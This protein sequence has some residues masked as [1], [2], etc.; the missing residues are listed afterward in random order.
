MESADA[1][2]VGGGIAGLSA[3]LALLRAGVRRVRLLERES[4]P[5][6]HSSGRNAAIFRHLSTTAG[7]LDLA[8]RSRE[9]L[10]ELLGVEEAWLRRTGLWFVSDKDDAIEPLAALAARRR[11]PHTRETGSAVTGALPSLDGGPL[12][13][14]LWCPDD[15]VIDI[16]A[17]TQALVRAI[18]AA[19][20]V[21]SFGVEVAS[22]DL[23]G[24]RVTGLHLASG[25][26]LAAG[27][28]VLAA[29]AWGASLGAS[30]GA[31]LPLEP[32]RRHLAQLTSGA[33]HDPGGP[34]VWCL[35]DELYYRPESGGVLVSP[36]DS[37]PC[38]AGVPP[39][40]EAGLELLAK[41]LARLAP[42]LADASV[43]R[44]WACL[45]TF[46]PDN[47]A[48]V[49]PDPRRQG[50]FWLAGLGGHGMTGGVAAGEL[51]AATFTGRA[52]PL[53]DALSVSRFAPRES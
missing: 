26:H 48:V 30:C 35:G 41:K 40:T 53:A 17:V 37:D 4:E 51:L 2:I 28:V 33:R 16:H 25:D 20:G 19:G 39:P 10:G 34:V 49:G 8:R 7:D 15:G 46:T 6:A 9:L 29:G 23:D 21:L 1:I 11:Q 3:A 42:R 5:C 31:P 22:V 38:L 18:G 45:R 24:D 50:L 36:C 27:A 44:A 43:R 13:R 32:R 14:G 12:A 52:H 47:A